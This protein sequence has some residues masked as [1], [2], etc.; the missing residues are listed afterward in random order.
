MESSLPLNHLFMI[1]VC[2]M[3]RF[4]DDTPNKALPT[5]INQNTPVVPPT[6]TMTWLN[7]TAPEKSMIP[8]LQPLFMTPLYEYLSCQSLNHRRG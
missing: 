5:N 7:T 2:E 6:I 1:A 8:I 3:M 4:S